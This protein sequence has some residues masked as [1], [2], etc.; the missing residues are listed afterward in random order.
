MSR[1]EKAIR[2]LLWIAMLG[3]LGAMASLARITR[4]YWA[5]LAL[6]PYIAIWVAVIYLERTKDGAR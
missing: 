6:V 3:S 4:T 1:D 5:L 2:W